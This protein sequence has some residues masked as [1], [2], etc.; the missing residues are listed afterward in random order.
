MKIKLWPELLSKI[1]YCR[2]DI[3]SPFIAHK[4]PIKIKGHGQ[5]AKERT[6]PTQIMK[7][8]LSREFAK[9]REASK[10]YADME[11]T[12]RPTFHEIRALGADL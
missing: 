11:E 9:A 5:R 10:F 1:G 2:D 3:A 8:E 7:E 6:H 4:K 12:A